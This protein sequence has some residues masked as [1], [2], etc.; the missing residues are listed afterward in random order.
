MATRSYILFVKTLT[1]KTSVLRV[2]FFSTTQD[3]KRMIH[4]KEGILPEHQR[5]IFAGR[6]LDDGRT[7][8]DYNIGP[9]TTIQLVL[10]LRGM[11]STFTSNDMSDT[12]VKYLMATELVPDTSELLA[13][14]REKAN[15]HFANSSLTFRSVLSTDSWLHVVY[16]QFLSKFLDFMWERT[17]SD[18]NRVDLRLTISDVNF[19]QLLSKVDN[20]MS[21]DAETSS[22]SA[23][24]ILAKLNEYFLECPGKG[25]GNG[26]CKPKIAFR[27]TKGPSLACINFHCDGGYATATLQLALNSP[28]EYNG[29]RLCFFVDDSLHTPERPAGSM[30]IHPAKVLH[31]VTALTSGT[32]KSL[33][34][35]DQL[36]GLGDGAVLAVSESDIVAFHVETNQIISEMFEFQQW[37]SS[38]APANQDNEEHL[39]NVCF[40]CLTAP[41]KYILIPCG[42]MGVCETCAM[43]VHS[44]CPICKQDVKSVNKVYNA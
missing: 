43:H 19:C 12:L 21:L 44:V 8:G 16:R 29:G 22:L 39:T 38:S 3:V 33:F 34:V 7:L 35:V 17:A 42:H 9:N 26:T 24:H 23:H 6:Q 37:S 41:P 31:G 18:E 20:A 28:D 30:T 36:N 1:N 2:D 4:D 40:I 32:R 14:L 25:L 15:A 10:R 27:I 5:L 11:I 13:A